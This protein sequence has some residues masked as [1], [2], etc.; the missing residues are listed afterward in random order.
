MKIRTP[1]LALLGALALGAAPAALAAAPA[2]V[3]HL[4]AKSEKD[5]RVEK[6]KRQH[7][8]KERA[9]DDRRDIKAE[10][11][12]NRHERAEDLQERREDARDRR[13]DDRREDRLARL[14]RYR[15]H[16]RVSQRERM[17]AYYR[18][19][20]RRG[21]CPPGFSRSANR[22][23]SSHEAYGWR[24]GY[25]LPSRIVYYELPASLY[26]MIEP[27]PYGYR[28]IQIGG[29]ILLI[30]LATLIVADSFSLNYY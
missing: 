21:H 3:V 10:R 7:D 14:E 17:N 2:P 12:E 27:A 24:A 16:M 6:H 28:Y 5:K 29:D 19:E 4:M 26:S 13:D 9:H 1:L 30:D 23:H 22:C 25:R 18:S 20:Y 15:S 8:R 11:R